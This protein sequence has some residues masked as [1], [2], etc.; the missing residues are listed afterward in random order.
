M[1]YQ[2]SA[3]LKVMVKGASYKADD[4]TPTLGTPNKDLKKLWIQ[5]SMSF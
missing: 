5:T 1:E 4:A 3:W 2:A